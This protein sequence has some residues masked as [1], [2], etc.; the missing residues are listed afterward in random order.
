MDRGFVWSSS[1]CCK[2]YSYDIGKEEEE[3]KE[4]VDRGWRVLES[5][6]EVAKDS[7]PQI[8]LNPTPTIGL[9]RHTR[10]I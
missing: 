2:L 9:R 5:Q 6:D 8:T 3:G 7:L 1:E 10:S 4:E